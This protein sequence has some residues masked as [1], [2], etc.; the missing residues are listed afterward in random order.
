MAINGTNGADIITGTEG[1]DDIFGLGGDDTLRGLGGNDLLD[2][3][4]GY[5]TLPGGAGTDTLTGGAGANIFLDSAAGFNGDRVTDF[6]PGDRI[7]FTDLTLQNAIFNIVGSTLTYNGGSLQIDGLG[8]GRFV[9]RAINGGGV[10][11]RLQENAHTDANGDGRSDFILR[12]SVSG[13]LTNWVAAPNGSL[14]SNGSNASIQFPAEWKVG[15]IAD[16]NGDGRDDFL[17]R[18][19]DGWLTNWIATSNGGYINNGANSTQFLTTDWKVVGTGNF[20]GDGRGDLLLR[21]DDGW[22]TNWLGTANGGYTNNGANTALFFTTDWKVAGTG[23]FNGD[24]ISDLLLRRD[25]GWVTNWL[26]TANGGFV[27][28]GANTS[29]FFT[30]DW[31]VVGTGDVNGD[32]ISD[33]VLRR[34]D[35]WLTDWLGTANGGFVN[36]G[37]NTALFFTPDWKVSAI[38]DFNGDAVDDILLRNDSGWF[39]NWLGNSAGSFTNN[40]ANFSAFVQPNWQVQDPFL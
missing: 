29:L 30:T 22:L 24:G 34:D 10:E 27:N 26:G 32:G 17:L 6:L 16:F 7:Q 18:R 4:A 12:D 39:T 1:N 21:R 23:D 8:P 2:G 20:N 11:I 25:D 31:K 9:I 38:G 36:N 15:G 19:D 14:S 35:G 28:N 37:A 33:L 40:G 3:G 5:A 13:W